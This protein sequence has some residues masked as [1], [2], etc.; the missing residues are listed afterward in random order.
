VTNDGAGGQAVP[1]GRR[2]FSR[3]PD[4]EFELAADRGTHALVALTDD[5]IAV[6]RPITVTN[7]T[8]ITPPIDLQTEGD[9]LVP[10][11]LTPTNLDGTEL[12]MRAV[13]ALQASDTLAL[14]HTGQLASTKVAPNSVLATSDVQE[15]TVTVHNATVGRTVMR[16]FRAGD[17][18]TFALP[19]ALGPV[20]FEDL[21]DVVDRPPLTC[22]SSSSMRSR[23]GHSRSRFTNVSAGL[24]RGYRRDA[25]DDRHRDRASAPSGS[26][27]PRRVS[28]LRGR[29]DSRTACRRLG[30]VGRGRRSCDRHR[31]L[32]PSAP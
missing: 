23:S 25:G 7:E 28:P 3:T 4:W 15:V 19:E 21:T 5:R 20:A 1:R 17:P 11:T 6:R 29:A 14:I 9:A 10:V 22:S 8:A 32:V 12:V 30:R 16:D 31:R 24:R 26:S 27:T 13:V 18:T 2:A